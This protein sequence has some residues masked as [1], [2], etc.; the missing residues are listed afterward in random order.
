[1]L[2]PGR[3]LHDHPGGCGG[4]AKRLPR[5]SVALQILEQE[6]HA[7]AEDH[8]IRIGRLE[9]LRAAPRAAEYLGAERDERTVARVQDL[10][11]VAL[12]RPQ[13]VARDCVGLERGERI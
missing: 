13:L 2:P 4:G 1:M 10:D 9:E 6:G 8:R 12:T 5:A 11:Q 7:V 3:G